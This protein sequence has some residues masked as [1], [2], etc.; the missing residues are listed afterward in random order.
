MKTNPATKTLELALIDL[1]VEFDREFR[2]D[3]SRLWRAD[4]YIHSAKLLIEIEGGVWLGRA[5]GHTSGKG[6]IANC[7]K[8]NKAT[9]MGFK[10]LRYPTDQVIS[11]ACLPQIRRIIGR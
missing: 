10:L 5:G 11:L 1:N 7:E 2:F 9:E 6:F 4:F 8:Y 3:P